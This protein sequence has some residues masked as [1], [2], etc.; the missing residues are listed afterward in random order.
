MPAALSELVSGGAEG[1]PFYMEELVK[2][3]IDQGAIET[4][5]ERW[6][7]HA[8]KLLA[9]QVPPS[10]TGVLQARLD[11]LPQPER[12]ALQEASVIGL[13]FWD[14]ALAALDAQAPEAL[15]A[16]VRRELTLPRPD[17]TL[18]DVREYAFSHQILHQVTY[19]TVLKRTRRALHA[20]AAAWLAGLTG[21]RASD[22]LGAAAEHYELAGDSPQACEFFTRA[23]EH[24]KSRYAHDAALGHVARALALLDR[25][26]ATPATPD[27]RRMLAPALAAA[28]RARDDAEHCRAI[29]PSS[30]PRSTRCRRWPMR[31]TTT[32]GARRRP[33]G[34]ACSRCARPTTA[35]RRALPAR[36]WRWPSAP[37]TPS[38]GWTRSGCWPMR[39][40]PSA[41]SRPARCWPATAW[42]RRARAGCAGSRACFSMRCRSSPSCRTTRSRGWRSISRTCRS[43]ASSATGRARRSRSATSAPTGSGSAS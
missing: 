21:A 12:L 16:L 6:T 43:G 33:G 8:E 14:Q 2:M 31:W 37:A 38:R 24:A 7:L 34:A 22:F 13:V 1:N 5:G 26:A 10:L 15:P 3:L 39:W 32:A 36:P 40:P 20:R 4:A 25:D 42:P 9:T 11:G 19:D 29:A 17:A 27:R 30:A 41:T 28:G 35:P 23:A 18:D